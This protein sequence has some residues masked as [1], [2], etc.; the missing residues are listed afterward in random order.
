[1]YSNW[2]KK[3]IVLVIAIAAFERNVAAVHNDL[4]DAYTKGAL[5]KIVYRVIDDK[6]TPVSNATVQV[7]FKSDGRPQ[8]DAT[9]C[10]PTDSNGV[11]ST[12]HRVNDKVSCVIHKEGYYLS[13]DIR[14]FMDVPQSRVVDGRW[15]PYGEI[16][17]I[18]LKKI[19]CPVV[20]GKQY[21]EQSIPVYG[22]WCGYDL[23]VADWVS[24]HGTGKCN[25]MMIRFSS[26]EVSPVDFGYKMELSFSHLP[27]A[28]VYVQRKETFSGFTCAYSASTNATYKNHIEFEVDRTGATRRIWNQLDEGSYLVFRTRTKTDVHG[29]LV[30]AH[31]G[32]IDGKWKFHEL[33][34]MKIRG[35]YFNSASNDPNL[36]DKC[37]FEETMLLQGA[38]Q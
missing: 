33:H 13:H 32:R 10:L 5:A 29:N 23:E 22:E 26:R 28:G 34:R 16:R 3:A 36:E 17:T 7:T 30:S 8:D 27:F 19:R 31:Y 12:A 1:M 18:V 20:E 24:P 6:G 38:Y 35:I 25:D 14:S 9:Y 21:V 2:M 11:V 15:Q 37:S 4:S